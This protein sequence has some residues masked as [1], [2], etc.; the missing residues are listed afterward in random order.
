MYVESQNNQNEEEESLML[1]NLFS[2]LSHV[3]R[4]PALPLLLV[5]AFML[6]LV[7]SPAVVDVGR[8]EP[9]AGTVSIDPAY[10]EIPKGLSGTVDV[11]SDGASNIY[12]A[13]FTVTFDQ[14]GL[15]VVD[16]DAGKAGV[17]ISTGS[18]PA[19]DFVATNAADNTAGT[20]DYA[21]TQL[22]P[23][24]P[25]NGG[26]IATIEFQCR[27]TLGMYPVTITESILSDP[28]GTP[29]AHSTQNGEIECIEVGCNIVGQAVPQGHPGDATGVEVCLDGTECT[30]MAADG[31]FS[32]FAQ[33]NQAHTITADFE[34]H[35]LS[36][37]NVSECLAA[38][39]VNIGSTT[40]RAGDLNED[41]VINILDL[42]MVGGNFNLS[43][44]T[45]W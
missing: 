27:D 22:S 17:Q 8:A 15:Q 14:T 25:C 21:V 28:D 23:T 24:S 2:R 10:Q 16:A 19:P 39:T 12:G 45:G 40:L 37:Y 31:S 3:V 42:V 7:A 29:I 9:L 18:C 36:Q 44:P 4:R 6:G 34:A 13:Q 1:S 33:A 11:R 30:T 41:D 32:I 35:L 38:Q 20:V 5:I 26:V 43:E